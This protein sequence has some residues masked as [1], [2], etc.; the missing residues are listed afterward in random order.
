VMVIDVAD[1]LITRRTDYWDSLT[2]VRQ[3]EP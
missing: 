3:L 2:Y 1:G